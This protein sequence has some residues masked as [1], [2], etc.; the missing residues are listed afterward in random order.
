MA[1]WLSCRHPSPAVSLYT[2]YAT[3]VPTYQS[4]LPFTDLGTKCIL[5]SKFYA[6]GTYHAPISRRDNF[7]LTE[8][9]SAIRGAGTHA[10]VELFPR[11]MIS[12]PPHAAILA[13]LMSKLINFNMADTL[14]Y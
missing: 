7:R 9:Q 12:P 1:K 5:Q 4:C 6:F 2:V 3:T 13:S 14:I 11:P 8:R 10:Q